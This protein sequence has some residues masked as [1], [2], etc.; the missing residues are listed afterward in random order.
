[1][2]IF[3]AFPCIV[4]FRL[5]NESGRVARVLY[6]C[7]VMKPARSRL[8]MRSDVFMFALLLLFVCRGI[9]ASA[10]R[11]LPLRLDMCILLISILF[12]S[13]FIC[14]CFSFYHFSV[15]T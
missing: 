5:S 4:A 15:V 9:S 1:M 14:L 10:S 11:V 2:V 3:F 7:F 13:P 12:V 8:F 6:F